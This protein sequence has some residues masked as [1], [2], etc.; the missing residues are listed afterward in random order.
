MNPQYVSYH[1]SSFSI[2]TVTTAS[3]SQDGVI[4]TLALS[5]GIYIM[6]FHL[7]CQ[8]DSQINFSNQDN[9]NFITIHL[10]DWNFETW[11]SVAVSD[12][13]CRGRLA[14]VAVIK[15]TEQKSYN[16]IFGVGPDHMKNN[17]L[18]IN[19][20]RRNYVKLQTI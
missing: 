9:I 10:D 2:S 3:G 14:G 19:A 12:D 15:V 1:N 18:N 7:Y 11:S 16:V 4:E 20:Y 17:T 8:F 6:S 5:P 13:R